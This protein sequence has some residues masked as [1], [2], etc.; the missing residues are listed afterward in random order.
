MVLPALP[1]PKGIVIAGRV[2]AAV[3]TIQCTCGCKLPCQPRLFLDDQT[4]MQV[5][6]L[7]EVV[8]SVDK[9]SGV[10]TD[11]RNDLSHSDLTVATVWA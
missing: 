6:L 10:L 5:T 3:H 4:L 2:G 8:G 9:S 7:L 11:L 1:I